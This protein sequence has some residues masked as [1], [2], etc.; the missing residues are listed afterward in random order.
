LVTIGSRAAGG[1]RGRVIDK[2]IR[3]ILLGLLHSVIR[4]QQKLKGLK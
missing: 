1:G 2:S 3:L 4:I